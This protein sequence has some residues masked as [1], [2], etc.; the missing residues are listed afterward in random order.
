MHRRPLPASSARLSRRALLQGIAMAGALAGKKEIPSPKATLGQERPEPPVVLTEDGTHFAG[1]ELRIQVVDTRIKEAFLEAQREFE[2]ATG[3]RVTIVIDPVDAAYS[4]LAGNITSEFPTIDGSV[5][6]MWRLGDMVDRDYIVPYDLYST[7]APR[8]LPPLDIEDELPAIQDLRRFGDEL[9]AVPFDCEGH[10]LFYRRDLFDDPS[11]IAAFHETTG[12]ELRPPETWDELLAIADYFERMTDVAGMVLPQR[13]GAQIALHYWSISA[14]FVIGAE[15]PL[16]YWFDPETMRPLLNSP[17]HVAAAEVMRQLF[18]FGPGAQREWTL[19]EAW[20]YFLDGH[21]AMTIGWPDLAALA[22]QRGKPVVGSLGAVRLPGT[23]RY[24]DPMTNRAIVPEATNVVG[25]TTGS[26]WA[27]VITSTSSHPDAVYAFFSVLANEK[28]QAFYAA[29]FSDGVDPGRRSQV[30]PEAATEGTGN[31]ETYL[32]H[33]W[34]R[35]DALDLTRAVYDTF[36]NPLQL[37]L[38]RI[39]GVEEYRASVELRL[40]AYFGREIGTAQEAMDLIVADMTDIT[41]RYGF[42]KQQAS[43]LA[44]LGL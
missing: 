11:H 31:L 13:V 4:R 23:D 3:A 25:N 39:P 7:N 10:I 2:A 6:A 30:P 35:E 1:I 17:G 15:N 8:W 41:I 36:A 33:G 21:A 5:V 32:A 38:L 27:G 24:V 29:R 12:R 44:S 14:P 26:S 22:Y 20:D 37:P 43:Y 40:A 16:A 9:Y 18:V 34:E 42:E 28:K 19:G